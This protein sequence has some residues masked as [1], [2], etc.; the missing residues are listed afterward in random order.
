[1]P[2][3]ECI[4]GEV[5]PAAGSRRVGDLM[6]PTSDENTQLLDLNDVELDTSLVPPDSGEKE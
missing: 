2:G 1:M 3:P 6:E 5:K 4:I